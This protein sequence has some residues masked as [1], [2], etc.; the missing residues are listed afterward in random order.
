[1]RNKGTDANPHCTI[2][3]P[4]G[5]FLG[6]QRLIQPGRS[7]Q[8]KGFFS[9]ARE[10]VYWFSGNQLLRF[11]Q[12]ASKLER[13][14]TN[15]VTEVLLYCNNSEYSV[16]DQDISVFSMVLLMFPR[17]S[18]T[19]HLMP[20]YPRLLTEHDQPPPLHKYT[21]SSRTGAMVISPSQGITRW[22]MTSTCQ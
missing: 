20:F 13:R 6:G 5:M 16:H 9:K 22:F 10:L 3:M 4:L 2:T 14:R 11:L 17:C 21:I 18:H 7:W 19:Q 15:S 12:K 1:M 8:R